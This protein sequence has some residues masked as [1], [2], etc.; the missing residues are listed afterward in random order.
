MDNDLKEWLD[1]LQ[2]DLVS[3]RLVSVKN[4][5]LLGEEEAL[6]P[7]IL[8]LKDESVL[9]QKVAVTALWELANPKVVPHLI[10][11]LGSSDAE[12]REEARSALSELIVS[13]DLLL[14]LDALLRDNIN[15]QLNILFLLR[16]IHDIQALPAI[17]PFLQSP[18]AELRE[19]AITTLR[20]L[21][22]VE[23]CEPALVL[24]TDPEPT[25]RR[26]TALTLG[27]LQDKSVISKLSQALLTDTD[28]ET[29]RNAAKALAIHADLSAI[30]ALEKALND[31]HWQVRRFSL[32]A[33]QKIPNH[34]LLS[35]LIK[36]LTDEFSDV[37]KDAAIALG[38][39]KN[40]QA[41]PALEQTLDDPDRDVAIYAQRAIQTIQSALQEHA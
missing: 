33:L 35:P 19:A 3:D 4:L 32:Q 28:W 22:Q 5:Q 18:K 20:Y 25:V 11:F 24:L 13:D 26:A 12:V 15:L 7:L 8:V 17:L 2:S 34:G 40:P 23:R 21:N 1:L 16:K 27:H 29:R 38:L 9:V 10:P 41:L 31:Q 14:L 6:E 30:N 39:L 37:R 36:A